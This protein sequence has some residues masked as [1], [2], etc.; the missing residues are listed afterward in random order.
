MKTKKFF[1][2]PI[3]LAAVISSSSYAS[4]TPDKTP[5]EICLEQILKAQE[6]IGSESDSPLT[7]KVIPLVQSSSEMFS[8][9]NRSLTKLENDLLNSGRREVLI[10][11]RDSAETFHLMAGGADSGQTFTR[12]AKM[13]LYLV[14]L[15]LSVAKTNCENALG[16]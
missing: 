7:R 16:F 4:E 15:T 2:L 1:V 14:S 3:I 6:L 12:I 10:D 5:A 11:V 8:T 13:Q 9:L